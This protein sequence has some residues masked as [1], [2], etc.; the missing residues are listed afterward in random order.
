MSGAEVVGIA[1]G[2][3]FLMNI[4]V[5]GSLAGISAISKRRNAAFLKKVIED[6]S[7]S[8]F[9][10]AEM[11][12]RYGRNYKETIEAAKRAAMSA[13]EEVLTA[14]DFLPTSSD[15]AAAAKAASEAAR[16]EFTFAA[17]RH[18]VSPNAILAAHRVARN[19]FSSMSVEE[20]QAFLIQKGRNARD[21]RYTTD[22]KLLQSMARN[23]AQM[24][25]Y[26][27]ESSDGPI[28]FLF[29]EE[30]LS[31]IFQAAANHEIKSEDDAIEVIQTAPELADLVETLGEMSGSA[32]NNGPVAVPTPAYFRRGGSCGSTRRRS[33]RRRS[34]RKRSTRRNN[35]R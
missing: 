29:S 27:R 7:S 28:E 33:T 8:G 16:A 6:A 14:P 22:L 30:S 11:V 9:E 21:V 23:A 31:A 5:P 12:A 26:A 15:L 2:A 18:P 1:V 3:V 32:N 13:A 19:Q 17:A 35:R 4:L 10:N 20:L 24:G 25:G 34:T